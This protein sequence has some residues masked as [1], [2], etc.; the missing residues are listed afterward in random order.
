M[1]GRVTGY[2]TK[3][4]V[5][6]PEK[7][8]ILPGDDGTH[9]QISGINIPEVGV[10]DFNEVFPPGEIGSPEDRDRMEPSPFSVN[11]V[12]YSTSEVRPQHMHGALAS[13]RASAESEPLSL[14]G[15]PTFTPRT[16][17]MPCAG[18]DEGFLRIGVADP[19]MTD[20]TRDVAGKL[21]RTVYPNDLYG[22]NEAGV[23][24]NQGHPG[25]KAVQGKIQSEGYSKKSAGAILASASRNA[26]GAAK[27]SNPRLNRVKG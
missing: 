21:K 6:V 16:A 2:I 10:K 22:R 24:H 15:Y 20:G 17:P 11:T 14:Q 12:A 4:T 8:G 9:L 3:Q 5:S 27:K 7:E 18:Q 26:S 19:M 23:T 13:M 25:F 1:R